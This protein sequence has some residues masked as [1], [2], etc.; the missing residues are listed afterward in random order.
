MKWKLFY[1][2]CFV[3]LRLRLVKGTSK[4]I[5]QILP[6][7]TFAFKLSEKSHLSTIIWNWDS[8]LIEKIYGA[9]NLSNLSPTMIILSSR[10]SSPH[11]QNPKFSFPPQNNFF[12]GIFKSLVPPWFEIFMSEKPKNVVNCHKSNF[13]PSRNLN[14]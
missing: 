3:L 14:I 8:S 4:W 11:R 12:P 9:K 13:H 6:C 5:P 2:S 10:V 7:N 1:F